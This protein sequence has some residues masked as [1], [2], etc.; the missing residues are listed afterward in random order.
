MSIPSAVSASLAH[1]ALDAMIGDDSSSRTMSYEEYDIEAAIVASRIA[2]ADEE[3]A[4]ALQI[5][6]AVM[7]LRFDY[8]TWVG[9]AADGG[10]SSITFDMILKD[11]ERIL[12]A[13]SGE[14]STRAVEE[15]KAFTRESTLTCHSLCSHPVVCSRSKAFTPSARVFYLLRGVL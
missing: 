1:Q 12:K 3:E 6:S 8:I 9:G 5:G 13:P 11:I 10:L 7:D 14:Y 2:L 15:A 4:S